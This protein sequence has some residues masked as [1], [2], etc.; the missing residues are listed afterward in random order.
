MLIVLMY[1]N[2]IVSREQS[3]ETILKYNEYLKYNLYNKGEY[4][5]TSREYY[6]W[7]IKTHSIK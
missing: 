4:Y 5:G 7:N 2:D 1:H 6:I 3:L